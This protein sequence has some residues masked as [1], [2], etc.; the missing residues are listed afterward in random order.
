[1]VIHAGPFAHGPVRLGATWSAATLA[2]QLAR[3]AVPMFF[4]FAGYFWARHG[5]APAALLAGAR[6]MVPRLLARFATW[7]LIFLI[8][9]ESDRI[10]RRFPDGFLRNLRAS[11]DWVA[12]HPGTVLLQGSHGH[13]WFLIALAMAVTLIALVRRWLPMRG[14]LLLGVGLFVVSLLAGAYRRT[15]LGLAL[16]FNPR[17]GPGFAVLPVAIGCWLAGRSPS[18]WWTRA[19]LLLVVG[20]ALV[21]AMELTWL[22]TH[23]RTSLAQDLVVGTFVMGVGAALLGL[24]APAWLHWPRLAT[25]GPWVLGLYAAHP[26]LAELLAPVTRA[27]ASPWADLAGLAVLFAGTLGVV[28]GLGRWRATRWLVT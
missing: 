1:M 15:P 24:S 14:V 7:S 21:A 3:F 9:F 8:P 19:G 16:P 2:N 23:Y 25:L 28:R 18:P 6:A 5:D 17:N 26:I 4:V 20:G 22:H 13:L 27:L 10:L 11:V 12:S